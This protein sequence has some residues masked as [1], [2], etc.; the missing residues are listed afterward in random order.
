[1]TQWYVI[2]IQDRECNNIPLLD[3]NCEADLSSLF[4]Q[5]SIW[6]QFAFNIL[7]QPTNSRKSFQ[8]KIRHIL[9]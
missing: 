5:L 3:C 4:V 2:N 1:M 6:E 7:Q 9:R 8:I